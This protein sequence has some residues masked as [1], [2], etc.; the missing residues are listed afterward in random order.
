MCKKPYPQ[1]TQNWHWK[2]SFLCFRIGLKALSFYA[3]ELYIFKYCAY[4]VICR[5]VV[6]SPVFEAVELWKWKAPLPKLSQ[7]LLSWLV[8]LSCW[9]LAQIWIFLPG[10]RW[11]GGRI[12]SFWEKCAAPT[13]SHELFSPCFISQ[14]LDMEWK[15]TFSFL[16]LKFV[17]F[18]CHICRVGQ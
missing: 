15:L 5:T 16:L 9:V 12:Y 3:P 6:E 18:L 2:P 11:G 8:K 10:K 7:D 1:S 4:N 17:L 13:S 14:V